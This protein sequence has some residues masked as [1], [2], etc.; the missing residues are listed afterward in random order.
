MLVLVT[1]FLAGVAAGYLAGGRLHNLSDLDLARPW[2][3]LVALG[4]QLVAFSPVG[5]AAGTPAAVALHLVSYALLAWFVVL[6]HRSLG[7]PIAGLGMGLNLVAI[8]VN[9]GYMPASTSAL[10]TA[11]IAYGDE[12]HNNSAIIDAGTRLGFLGD[13]FAVPSWVPAANVFS[14]GDVLI[15]IGIAVLLATSMRGA[16]TSLEAP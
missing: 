9:G 7:V 11:G 13:I 5:A 6:N 12:T 16:R 8:T 1:A 14:I 10:A 2:I 15:T 3:V 4:L